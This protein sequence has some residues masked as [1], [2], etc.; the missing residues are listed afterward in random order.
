MLSYVKPSRIIQQAGGADSGVQRFAKGI[1]THAVRPN[2]TMYDTQ[3]ASRREISLHLKLCDTCSLPHARSTFK[4]T[5]P[6]VMAPLKETR[7]IATTKINQEFL[8]D[9]R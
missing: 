5:L 3:L 7:I 2:H 8:D 9:T 1:T 4:K 6:Q